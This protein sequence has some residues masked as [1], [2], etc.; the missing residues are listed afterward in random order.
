MTHIYISRLLLALV[1]FAWTSLCQGEP[2]FLQDNDSWP[3]PLSSHVQVY[4]DASGTMT[5][6]QAALLPLDDPSGFQPGSA[7]DLQIGYSRSAWWLSMEI[8]NGQTQHQLFRLWPG[9]PAL[10]RLDYYIKRGSSWRHIATGQKEPL[11]KQDQN[12]LHMQA[13]ALSLGPGERNRILMRLESN[14]AIHLHPTI[15]SEASFRNAVNRTTLW[16]GVLFGGLLS[17]AWCA[18]LIG[19]LSPSFRFIVL[20]ALCIIITLYEASIR[21]YTK[22]YLWPETV[23][24]AYRSPIVLGHLSLSVFMAFVLIMA[25]SEKI[26]WPVRPYFTA[27]AALELIVATMALF[28]DPYFSAHLGLFTSLLFGVSMPVAAFLLLKNAAPTGR[29]MLLTGLFILFHSSLRTAERLGFLPQFVTDIGLGNPG[30]NPIIA[31]G[32]LAINLAVLTAWIVLIGK[33]R[34]AAQDTLIDWQA[35]EQERLKGQIALKTRELH[36]ALQYAEEKNRQ[37]TETLGYIG[38]DLRAP[39]AT[40][41]GYTRLLGGTMAAEQDRNV[42]AIERSAQYQLKLIDELLEYAKSE[43]KP[44]ELRPAPTDM[45]QTLDDILQ[46]ALSLCSQ[47]NNQFQIE[48]ENPIPANAVLDNQRLQQVLLNLISNAAKFTRNG[49]IRLAVRADPDQSGWLLTFA[50]SDTGRGID[51]G[52]QTLIFGAFEQEEIHPGSAGLGLY[53]AQRIVENMGGKLT[54]RSVAGMGSQFSFQVRV[55]AMDVETITWSGPPQAVTPLQ[56]DGGLGIADETPVPPAEI[57]MDLAKLARNGQLSDIEDWL[58]IQ[59]KNHPRYARFFDDIWNAL[60]ILDL[61]RIESMALS[62]GGP[63]H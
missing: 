1:V 18:L 27:L 57:R 23:E 50:V 26:H 16:D 47:Q 2:L 35:Q 41:V 3:V 15:Y 31:L 8:V 28:F 52:K 36:K 7:K 10:A 44:L 60:H 55:E 63:A 54:V 25:R 5:I 32:G 21:N 53:I 24:W 30:T 9:M 61:E 38:H 20:S 29:L 13:L 62:N 59:A 17:L 22:L 6:D 49:Y 14:T 42:R 39:A 12:S 46:Y 45:A 33:Q 19:L 56:A 11:S 40:I 51:R 37:K 43:L 58:R 4:E 34:Q 48:T